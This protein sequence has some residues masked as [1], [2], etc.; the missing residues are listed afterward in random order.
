MA[1]AAPAKSAIE[2]GAQASLIIYVLVEHKRWAT[3][4]QKNDSTQYGVRTHSL[5]IKSPTLFQL[6]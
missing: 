4:D 1:R 6:S 5:W 2:C 3:R